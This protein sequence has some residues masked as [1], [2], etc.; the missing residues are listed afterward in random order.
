MIDIYQSTIGDI[1][2]RTITFINPKSDYCLNL[3]LCSERALR[4][5]EL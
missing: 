4:G 1:I 3:L 2:F 5:G